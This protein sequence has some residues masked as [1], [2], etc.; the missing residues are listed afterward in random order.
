LAGHDGSWGFRHCLRDV[1]GMTSAGAF[2]DADGV[3]HEFTCHDD[4]MA[5][6]RRRIAAVDGD[7]GVAPAVRPD[8]I[9]IWSPVTGK[10]VTSKS[11]YYKDVRRAGCEI[12]PEAGIREANRPVFNSPG[13]ADD[14]RR[15]IHL[16]QR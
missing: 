11:S 8:A 13:L 4:F 7:R 15:A 10:V 6:M 1:L 2:I 14:I 3:R 9:E 16:T 12:N 5:L